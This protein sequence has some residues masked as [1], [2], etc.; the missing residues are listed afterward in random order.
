MKQSDSSIPR[1]IPGPESPVAHH[2]FGAIEGGGTKFVL[3]AGADPEH[4][5]ERAVVPTTTPKETIA[6]CVDFFVR[7]KAR[8]ALAGLG[9]A[10][11]GPVD[12]NPTSRTYGYV[13]TTP[14]PGWAFTDVV[15]PLR[16]ALGVPIGWEHDVTGALLGERR[17]GAARDH[18]PVMYIVVG[19]GVGG[20]AFVNGA[21]LRGLVHLEMGHLLMPDLPG[22]QF[23]GACPFHGRCLEG[24]ISGPAIA[25]R[26]GRPAGALGE[27]DP[28]WGLVAE[29]LAMA[30]MDCT[31]LLSPRRIV[32]GGGVLRQR[33]I[34]PMV[35]EALRRRLNGYVQHPL[36]AERLD[37]YVVP[38]ALGDEAG[39]FGALEIARLA[40]R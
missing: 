2:V 5:V 16:R 9:V 7:L 18:D 36:L 28:L 34:I 29:Y 22:D 38:S 35:R 27:Q 39:A 6:A 12:L 23:A 40:A 1:S 32:L 11:F 33:Q 17:W 10:C 4:I 15:G 3:L 25:Q 19:T 30:L 8:Y 21:P 37:E 13:T 26:A 20:G 31:L 14:K 24:L